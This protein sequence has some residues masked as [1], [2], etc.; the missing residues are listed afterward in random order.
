MQH[1][2]LIDAKAL[3]YSG[4]HCCKTERKKKMKK[5]TVILFSVLAAVIV[6]FGVV[7]AGVAPKGLRG[8]KIITIEVYAGEAEGSATFTINTDEAYLGKALQ[9][10]RIVEGEE[11]PYGLFITAVNGIKV[12]TTKEQW[13]CITKGGEDLYSGVDTTPIEDGDTFELTLKTGY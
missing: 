8:E 1:C 7:Y 6:I 3:L 12:D 11:G 4:S 2:S 9:N 10:E 5:N 13:W